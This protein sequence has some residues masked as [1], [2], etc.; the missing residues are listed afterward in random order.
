M[1]LLPKIILVEDDELDAEMTQMTLNEIPL[2]NEVVWLENGEELIEYLDKEGTEDVG[3]CI[4]DLKM[5]IMSGLE[6]LE[7]IKG[8]PEKYKPFPIVILTSSQEQPEVKR[9]YDLGVNAFITKPVKQDEF[10][11][12]IKILGLFWGLLNILPAKE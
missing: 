1:T 2:A 7:L 11:H 5:P 9:C 4:L 8:N 6:A 10:K 3:L 12:A